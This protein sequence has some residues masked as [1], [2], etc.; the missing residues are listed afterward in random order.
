[1]GKSEDESKAS[2]SETSDVSRTNVVSVKMPQFISGSADAWFDI[3]EAQFHL[4]NITKSSTKYYHILSN[5][6]PDVITRIDPEIRTNHDYD[7]LRKQLIELYEQSKTEMFEKMMEKTMVTGKPSLFLHEL[8]ELSNKIN[9]G[10]NF[11]R[12]K[13]IHGLLLFIWLQSQTPMNSDQWE[14]IVV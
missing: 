10:D 11:L 5:L 13:F 1:M 6:P 4:S 14:I 3:A 8:I 12:E 7:E 2:T 9:V